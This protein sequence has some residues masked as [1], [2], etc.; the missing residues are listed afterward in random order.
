VHPFHR[1]PGFVIPFQ[2]LMVRRKPAWAIRHPSIALSRAE[3]PG[4]DV[5][6]GAIP[7]EGVAQA[8]LR[9]SI[10]QFIG[11]PRKPHDAPKK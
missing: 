6:A 7:C 2:W 5:E 9:G 4:R 8:K 3:R 11:S 1:C 10:E